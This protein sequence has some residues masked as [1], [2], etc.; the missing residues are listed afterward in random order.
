MHQCCFCYWTP[1]K[2]VTESSSS[3]LLARFYYGDGQVIRKAWPSLLLRPFLWPLSL[4]RDL[5]PRPLLNTRVVEWLVL[6]AA[7][8]SKVSLGINYIRGS[9]DPHGYI[10]AVENFAAFAQTSF[11]KTLFQTSKFHHFMNVANLQNCFKHFSNFV[12]FGF[13]VSVVSRCHLAKIGEAE[14][15]RLPLLLR[16]WNKNLL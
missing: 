9:L 11:H 4:S 3:G 1:G 15:S 6:R 13:S 10:T 7:E 2:P 8:R 12:L 16:N 14:E 5:I